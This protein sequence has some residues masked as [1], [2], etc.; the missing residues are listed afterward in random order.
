MKNT[1]LR[2]LLLCF[3]SLAAAAGLS[4][5]EPA[6]IAKARAYLGS[7]S[8]LNSVNSLH[9]YGTLDLGA[10]AQNTQPIRV[11]ILFERPF[12][13]RSVITSERG[14]E[15]TVLDGY[16]AWQRVNPA[17]DNTRWNLAVLQAPQIK[18]LRAN[19]WENL[20]FFRGLES[21]GGRIDDLG[22]VTVDGQSC[23][24]LAFVHSPEIIFYRYF[25]EQ[26]GRLVLTETLRGESIRESGT[27]EVAG[28]KFPKVLTTVSTRPDGSTQTVAINF[29]KVEVNQPAPAGSFEVPL[30]ISN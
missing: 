3:V 17:G 30:L 23:R 12:R 18:N 4:A 6:I 9:F 1:V 14:I 29:D 11:E 26:T 20:S 21:V 2:S 22:S 5:A 15:I 16:D 27:M 25:N 28:I 8:A 13:Q 10:D 19:A 24:K 7:E